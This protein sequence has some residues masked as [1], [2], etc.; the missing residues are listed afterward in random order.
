MTPQ[1]LAIGSSPTQQTFWRHLRAWHSAHPELWISGVL[2]LA[3]SFF[4][5]GFGQAAHWTYA[6]Q[7]RGLAAF[8][9][10]DCGWYAS[11]TGT[12]Y[13]TAPHHDLEGAA[14]WAFFPL[15]PLTGN[16]CK[17]LFHLDAGT[18]TVLAS[19][20]EYFAAILAF[21]LWM[22]P[23]LSGLNDRF[24]AGALVA[25]NPYLIYGH[26]GYSEPLYFTVCC[27]G[28]W[29]L[30]QKKWIVAG[31]F[32]ACLS[33]TRM[34]GILFALVYAISVLRTVGLRSV[35]K[36]RSL[37]ILI[38][39]GLCPLGLALY[40]LYLHHHTGDALAFLH[41]LIA[42][43]RATTNP[44]LVMLHSFRLHGWFR[45]WTVMAAGGLVVSAWLMRQ[46]PEYASFLALTILMG[47]SSGSPWGLPRY[48]WWQPPLLYV[49]YFWL[50]RSPP[51][52]MIYLAFAAGMAS[53]MVMAWFSATNIV[54]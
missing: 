7:T 17:H 11:V 46:R 23:H 6:A 24:F 21:L 4:V 15:F 22:S 9:R 37:N 18:A 12:G 26:S 32:G 14:N 47:M 45:V 27:L 35:V 31:V 52:W 20:I 53:F 54:I 50:R 43:G 5:Y 25:F 41:V 19:R 10:W 42:W 1:T 51:A 38:G 29:A 34:V 36:G 39:L 49:I 44:L 2:F 33:A 13:D 48:L 28:F 30:E 3:S 8:C 16:A 40:T